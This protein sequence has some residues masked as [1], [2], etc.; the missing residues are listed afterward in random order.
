MCPVGH[1]KSGE[2]FGAHA[3]AELVIYHAEQMQDFG[4][5]R[6]VFQ[7]GCSPVTGVLKATLLLAIIMPGYFR[8]FDQNAVQPTRPGAKCTTPKYC[9]FARAAAAEK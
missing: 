7:Q 8:A 6:Q 2:R 5:L 9:G 4:I 1:R 3:L